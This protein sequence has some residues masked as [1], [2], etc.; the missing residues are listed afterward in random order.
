MKSIKADKWFT[1]LMIDP[2]QHFR[3]PSHAI[4]FILSEELHLDWLVCDFYMLINVSWSIISQVVQV[5][6]SYKLSYES[7]NF[8]SY[9]S[10]WSAEKLLYG[11]RQLADIKY[12]YE[13]KFI[14]SIL[15]FVNALR[16]CFC[17]IMFSY[18][19]C[20]IIAA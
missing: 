7:Q 12:F 9:L 1:I 5:R 14:M 8:E 20:K 17:K 16:L 6:I 15:T 18:L 10:L 11:L 13:K 3:S 4:P 2:L 19:F